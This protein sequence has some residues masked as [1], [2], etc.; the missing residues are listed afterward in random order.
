MAHD[1]TQLEH[2]SKIEKKIPAVNKTWFYP[3]L[4]NFIMS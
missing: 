2:I 1:E 4:P 3:R